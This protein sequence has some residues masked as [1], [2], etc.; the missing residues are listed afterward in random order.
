MIKKRYILI[1]LLGLFMGVLVI[2]AIGLYI[3]FL[4]KS[5][6]GEVVYK[7]TEVG[8][9]IGDKVT[10]DI[11]PAGGSIASPDGRLTLTVPRNAATDNNAFSIQPITNKADGGI[12]LG[13]R[14]E[15]NGKTFTIPLEISVRYDEHDLEGTV[16]QALSMAYQ[17]E[18]GS[19]H[20]QTSAKLD[21]GAKTITVSTTH[22]S[23]WSF[24]T[25][26]KLSPSNAILHVGESQVI[27]LVLCLKSSRFE[28]FF[29][30]EPPAH[31]ILI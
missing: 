23:D 26:L 19:W 3:L 30:R 16:P 11:G 18:K 15:P 27:S 5:A 10:K 28:R 20:A 6:G 13:Y 22:F 8:T 14:L 31:R 1:P 12:G 24:I 7:A 29:N 25:R 2:G 4:N 9:P 17:D 21:Q